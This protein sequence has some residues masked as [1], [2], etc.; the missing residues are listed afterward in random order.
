MLPQG[1]TLVGAIRGANPPE[2]TKQIT[3]QVEQEKKVMNGEAQR[4]EVRRSPVP[5]RSV[6]LVALL[7]YATL[8]YD[9]LNYIYD[10]LLYCARHD[11]CCALSLC[12]SSSTTRSPKKQVC[13]HTD[14][15]IC[16]ANETDAHSTASPHA[17]HL[18]SSPL[19]CSTCD[20]LV[21]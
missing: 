6:P 5:S 1:G 3:K 13:A 15:L 18:L 21:S 10:I 14:P 20:I 12:T 11:M 8:I 16:I 2:L 7:H 9:I 19:H 17:P 4:Q